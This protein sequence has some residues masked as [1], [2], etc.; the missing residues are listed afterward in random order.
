MIAEH[1]ANYVHAEQDCIYQAAFSGVAT[2]GSV[3]LSLERP[4]QRCLMAMHMAG[5]MKVYYVRDYHSIAHGAE[6]CSEELMN[7]LKLER[8]D[9]E[10]L[11]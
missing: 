4:C 7:K 8:I 9:E 6:F 1:T 10:S 11:T 2:A 3:V 5:V